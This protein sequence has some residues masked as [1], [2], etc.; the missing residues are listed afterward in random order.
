[1]IT[2]PLG[3]YKYI[4]LYSHPM[5]ISQKKKKSSLVKYIA[6]LVKLYNFHNKGRD[7]ILFFKWKKE[8]LNPPMMI[9]VM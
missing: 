7:S 4:T 8:N 9:I 3:K 5:F 1:M 6:N 2:L